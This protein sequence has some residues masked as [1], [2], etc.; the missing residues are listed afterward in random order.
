MKTNSDLFEA[1]LRLAIENGLPLTQRPFL[2]LA[3]ALGTTEDYVIDILEK[4]KRQGL[5][6]R[7]GLVVKHR[8]LGYEANAMVVWDIPDAIVDD[9]GSAF[10]AVPWVTLCY[11]RPRVLPDWPY[12][13]FCMIHGRDRDEVLRQIAIMAEQFDLGNVRRDVLFST[14]CFKQRGGRYAASSSQSLAPANHG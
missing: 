14:H 6:K 4:F 9:L 10:K 11:R 12:N 7:M 5:I 13:L 1:R 3:E 2:D 8:S